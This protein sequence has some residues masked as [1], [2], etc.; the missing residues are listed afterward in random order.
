MDNPVAELLQL[1]ERMAGMADA[2]AA[3]QAEQYME[4]RRALFAA[5]QRM[6]AAERSALLASFPAESFRSWEAAIQAM[7]HR[8]RN[9]A[10]SKL[11]RMQQA[12]Q[13]RSGYDA[14]LIDSKSFFF[15]RKK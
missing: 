9:D 3:E 6:P 10:R 12:K 11:M 2:A 4:R 15:D 14:P 7:L 1:T 5:I 13:Q 8:L